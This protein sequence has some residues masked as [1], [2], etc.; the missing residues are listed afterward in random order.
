VVANSGNVAVNGGTLDLSG[1]LNVGSVQIAA[2]GTLTGAGRINGS[3]ANS[4]TVAVTA[5]TLALNGS[6]LIN[7]GTMRFTGGAG[8]SVTGTLVNNGVL[9]IMTSGS[10]LPANFVNNGVVIDASSAKITSVQISG[11]GTTLSAQTYTGHTYQLQ[12]RDSL[13]S[14]TWQN[15]GAAQN[16]NNAVQ[17]FTDPNGGVNAKGFYRLQISP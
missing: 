7:S 3:F 11:S 1:T 17:S 12:T 14:G 6:S 8:L 16:G 2:A 9:D 10:G 4:G 5:G 13:T 15:I